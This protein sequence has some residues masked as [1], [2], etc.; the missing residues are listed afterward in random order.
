MIYKGHNTDFR[1]TERC[2]AVCPNHLTDTVINSMTFCWT[3][4]ITVP[5]YWSVAAKKLETTKCLRM[6]F[7][8]T[9]LKSKCGL[10]LPSCSPDVVLNNNYK[11]VSADLVTAK[12]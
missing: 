1:L 6:G 10:K 8:Y 7:K 5:A 9:I 12:L 11:R 3:I 2:N 4:I